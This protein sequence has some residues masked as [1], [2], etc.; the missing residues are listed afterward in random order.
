LN[1]REEERKS[2]E[3]EEK[4]RKANQMSEFEVNITYAKQLKNIL[5]PLLELNA[6]KLKLSFETIQ[7]FNEIKV[8][9]IPNNKKQIPETLKMVD[10]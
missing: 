5:E 4:K 6:K 3:E 9:S 10:S 8:G 2:K 7:I 1:R